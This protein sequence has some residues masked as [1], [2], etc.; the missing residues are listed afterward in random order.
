MSHVQLQVFLKDSQIELTTL[1]RWVQY[2]WLVPLQGADT[3]AED[4]L[5]L[6]QTDAA[7]ALLI[8]ELQGDFGVN[9]EGVDIVL[10][11]LDQLHSMRELVGQ[12][13]GQLVM[14][15]DAQ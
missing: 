15:G 11:L 10:H 8:Q 12:L 7:R 13:R 5:Q 6:S 2:Q 1:R 4:E 3:R 9:D 14:P